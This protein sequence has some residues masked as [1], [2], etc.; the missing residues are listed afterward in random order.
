[1]I[2][3][4]REDRIMNDFKW[5][6][7]RK[8]INHIVVVIDRSGSMGSCVEETIGGFNHKID[9]M[10][11]EEDDNTEVYVSLTQFDDEYE[12]N[13]TR[14]PIKE[15]QYLNRETYVPRGYT[16]LLDAVGKSIA[17]LGD[18]P[19]TEKVLFIIITDGQENA[20]R[21]YK[22]AQIA[23][24]IKDKDALDNW[25]FV[26]MGADENAWSQGTSFGISYGNIAH[27]STQNSAFAF[28]VT[29]S[30]CANF[31]KNSD[32]KTKCFYSSDNSYTDLTMGS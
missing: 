30:G 4:Y 17:A 22:H 1:M 31:I 2:G 29:A 16:A 15:V 24:M 27:Y 12:I 8:N 28:A 21:E 19:E 10:R 7:Y 25:S 11:A 26:F 23:Q 5:P 9:Q 3:M 13:Y 14:K 6:T 18:V 32:L 20:S